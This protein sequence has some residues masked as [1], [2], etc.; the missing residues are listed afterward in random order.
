MHRVQHDTWDNETT[1]TD[2]HN[3]N[4][5][6]YKDGDDY[7]DDNGEVDNGDEEEEDDNN[8]EKDRISQRQVV[9]PK[10]KQRNQVGQQIALRS[11][12]QQ[13]MRRNS[14]AR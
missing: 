11:S 10:S 2:G 3:N 7:D 9:R 12:V 5:K 6:N 4:N 14:N 8:Y 13:R 1:I